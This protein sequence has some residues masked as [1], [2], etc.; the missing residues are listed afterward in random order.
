MGKNSCHTSLLFEL[1]SIWFFDMHLD[2]FHNLEH[3]YFECFPNNL[4]LRLP[5]HIVPLF[6]FSVLW[7][8]LDRV[9]LKHRLVSLEF[10]CFVIETNSQQRIIGSWWLSYNGGFLLHKNTKLWLL[11]MGSSGQNQISFLLFFT[12]NMFYFVFVKPKPLHLWF[13]VW[14]WNQIWMIWTKSVS[15]WF[16]SNYK[17]VR[18]TTEFEGATF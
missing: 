13:I 3:F 18:I 17:I 6:L 1:W 7:S 4:L 11:W 14:I 10:I 12:S 5:S 9:A 8:V 2:V 15:F 16:C